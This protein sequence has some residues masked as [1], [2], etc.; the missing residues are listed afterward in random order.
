MAVARTLA[1][2]LTGVKGSLVEIEADL[3]TGLPVTGSARPS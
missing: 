2:A 1:V 3:T